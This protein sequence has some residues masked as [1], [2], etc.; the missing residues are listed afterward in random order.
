MTYNMASELA[1]H[2]HGMRIA[3]TSERD[4]VG[5][6]RPFTKLRRSARA[7]WWIP[8]MDAVYISVNTGHGMWLT[9][10]A[11]G[12]ARLAGVQIF[13]HHHS[14]AYLRERK[15][16]MVALTRAAGPQ[17]H[18]IVLSQS[19]AGDLTSVMPEIRRPLVIGNAAFI[20][21]ALLDLPLKADGDDLVFGHL[22]NLSRDKGIAE[23]VDLALALNRSGTQA[24]LLVGGPT[25]DG[26]SRLHLDRAARELG[27]LFEY[28]GQL[29]GESKHAFFEEITHFMF[30][31]RYHHE[32]VPLVL[33][34]AMAAGVICV[35]TGQGSIAEQL[36]GSPSVL[37]ASADSFVE[38]A[39]R[40]LMG[41]SVSTSSSRESRQAYLHA[42]AE[43]EMQLAVMIALLAKQL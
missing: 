12:L 31:S 34:E 32:A 20:D 27:G 8:R 15:I 4:A 9:T 42:L 25:V 13:L 18:H 11:A 33:Y 5:W 26:A 41:A 17:A 24:R 38:E 2:F 14:Y 43:S 37:T 40:A 1:P 23:V 3:D 6:I 39:R 19:M 7:W 35:A 36:D 30:P 21:R 10:V 28:R 22:S 29:T 16:R